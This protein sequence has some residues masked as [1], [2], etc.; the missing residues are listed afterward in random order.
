MA[1]KAT[2]AIKDLNSILDELGERLTTLTEDDLFVAWFL[3]A[4]ITESE[5]EAASGVVGGPGD[6][7]VD[8][9]LIDDRAKT[10]FVVQAKYR[11]ALGQKAENR[12]DLL[13]FADVAH[14]LCDPVES[15]FK[16]YVSDMDELTA[17]H[18]IDARKRIRGQDY[19]LRLF[20]VTL[21]RVSPTVVKD[22][23]D[24]VR[25]VKCDSAIE[26]LDGKRCMVILRDYLDGVA[27]PIPM[28]DLEMEATPGVR[29]NGIAN[30]FD[31]GA[32]IESWVFSMRGDAVGSLYEQAGVR[33]FARN[34]RGFLGQSTAVN[35]GMVKTLASEPERFFYYNNGVTIIC[36]S[37]EKKSSKG[38]DILQVSNPQVINGQQTTRNLAAERKNAARGSVL[39]K[40]ICVPRDERADGYDDLVSR[41]VAGTN[42]QNA[43][44]PSDLMSNDRRQIELE[45]ALRKLDYL[46]LRKRQSKGEARKH[47]GGKC[48]CVV[49][50]EEFAQA[51]A[52]AELDPIVIRSGRERLFEES[53]YDQIFPNADPEYYLARYWL[54]RAV[55]YGARRKPQRSYAKWLVLN[56]MWTNLRDLVRGKRRARVFRH[57]SERQN[58]S[59]VRPLGRC[60]NQAY[61]EA[62]AYYRL[63]R[64]TGETQIDISQFFRSGKGHHRKFENF[65]KQ[66][67]KRSDAV[68]KHG[69]QAVSKAIE[70]WEQ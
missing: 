44:K 16:Q 23:R 17:Q 37:A 58:R 36:D 6:K 60:V 27:P 11:R 41:I 25:R 53:Y 22:T 32:G 67:A 38:R 51:V 4:Y 45:R 55:T 63:N 49:T 15:S 3:R 62:L 9:V 18:I 57:L 31:Q 40:V 52:G 14:R 10:V 68:L 28:L 47:A 59:L 70:G 39:V 43:I 69:L 8:A 12:S 56:F 61:V 20:F 7:N 30:R 29:V 21:G 5:S 46:Y 66:R 48:K 65:W 35:D 34:V 50:K 1:K 24:T 19:R 26:I 54:M 33:L 2:L 13:G 42:W 64:G